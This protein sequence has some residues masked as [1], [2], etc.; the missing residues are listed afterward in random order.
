[1]ISYF[2]LGPF[3][4]F[5]KLAVT[6]TLFFVMILLELLIFF[7]TSSSFPRVRGPAIPSSSK[8][9]FYWNLI[10][11]SLV[12]EPKIPSASPQS[13][14]KSFKVSCNCFTAS[15][16]APKAN[17]LGFSWITGL[18]GVGTVVIG[19]EPPNVVLLASF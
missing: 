18:D 17:L 8:S 12:L 14:P 3:L 13:K 6:F 2:V 15:P 19:F 5:N 9:Y 4:I 11:C 7:L 10:T 16:I 1:M